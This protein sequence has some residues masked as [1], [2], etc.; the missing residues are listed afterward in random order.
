MRTWAVWL[1]TLTCGISVAAAAWALLA[2]NPDTLD[3]LLSAAVRSPT[4]TAGQGSKSTSPES[5]DVR[6]SDGAPASVQRGE[7]GPA[8]PEGNQG[9]AG[10]QG[11]PGPQGEAGPPGPRRRFR[12]PGAQRGPR[13]P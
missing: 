10:P 6:D 11:V 12:T 9:P 2:T 5:R 3:S 8:G 1:V 7:P 13:L 4:T